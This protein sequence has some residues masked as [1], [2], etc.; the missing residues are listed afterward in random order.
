MTK[1]KIFKS[2]NYSSWISIFYK[3]DF[4][5]ILIFQSFC[6]NICFNLSKFPRTTTIVSRIFVVLGKIR[7]KYQASPLKKR[8]AVARL[9][10]KF[11]GFSLFKGLLRRLVNNPNLRR[12]KSTSI[13]FL[14]TEVEIL[15]NCFP[16]SDMVSI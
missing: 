1:C 11:L 5:R 9:P 10:P 13:Y 8:K 16:N 14:L 12:A 15:C 2:G 7:K 6:F 3:T 4:E